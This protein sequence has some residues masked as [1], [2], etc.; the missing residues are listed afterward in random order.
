MAQVTGLTRGVRRRN[1]RLRALREHV[2]FENAVVG[3]DLGGE[4]QAVAVRDHDAVVLDQRVFEIE[5]PD[6]G[7]AIDWAIGRARGA[8]FAG[9]TVSCEPTG[10]RWKSVVDACRRRGVPVV[11]V[12]TMLVARGR[13]E[14][15]YRRA[16]TDLRDAA[17]LARRAIELKCF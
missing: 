15:D 17:L 6:V 10:F 12:H 14:E 5:A 16:K 4:K 7:A 11:C 2:R 1:R 9:V 3:I 8:G 13:E